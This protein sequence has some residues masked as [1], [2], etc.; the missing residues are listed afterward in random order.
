M[1]WIE[2]RSRVVHPFNINILEEA[3]KQALQLASSSEVDLTLMLVD[4]PRMRALNRKFRQVDASTD[5]LAFKG[6]IL[7]PETGRIHLGD[8]V[9][10]FPMALAQAEARGHSLEAE[11]QLLAVHGVL[12]LLGHDHMDRQEKQKM[13]HAQGE[14]LKRLG[15]E[16]LDVDG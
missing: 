12:H 5:V 4:D 9:I 16:N 6:D 3:A 14:V 13:W 1:I 2:N 11:M 10:S 15:L 8:V 7:D